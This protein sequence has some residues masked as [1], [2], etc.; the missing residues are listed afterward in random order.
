M[1]NSPVKKKILIVD[2][3]KELSSLFKTSLEAEGFEV[4]YCGDGESALQV[5]RNF[6]PDFILLDLMMPR[7]SGFEALELFRST[8]ETSAAKIVIFSALN[9]DEDIRRAKQLGADDYIVKSSTSFMNVIARIK[10]L[11]N[12]PS[13]DIVSSSGELK[14]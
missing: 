5:A 2:D 8:Y 13:S 14:T 1:D 7:L 6:R 10:E 3:E 4:Q 12:E 11:I 9:E